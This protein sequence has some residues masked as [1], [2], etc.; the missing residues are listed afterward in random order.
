MLP[1]V[2][3]DMYENYGDDLAPTNNT[4]SYNTRIATD[5]SDVLR[6]VNTHNR[7]NHQFYRL[8]LLHRRLTFT[9]SRVDPRRFEDISSIV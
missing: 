4:R 7:P 5:A 8:P 9:A 1:L 3:T 6:I 2:M